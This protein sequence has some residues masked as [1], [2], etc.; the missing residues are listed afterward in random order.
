MRVFGIDCGTE[1]TGF[2]CVE[3]DDNARLPRLISLG[4]G[5]IRLPKKEPLAQ[6][7]ALL[8]A[9]LTALI[10]AHQPDVVAIEEVFYSVNAKSALKL[11]QVR[12][13]ALLAAATANVPLAEYAPLKIKSTVTGYGLAEK[14]QV[15]FMVARLLDLPVV[16]EP[17]DAAD[18]LAIAICHIQHAQTLAMQS[19]NI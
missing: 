5:G 7:L 1:I 3:C 8:Y 13:V 4:A 6:R 10:A 14:Q 16:P 9:E 2:G 11:G 18:A 15:Q 19:I 17:A 12:G